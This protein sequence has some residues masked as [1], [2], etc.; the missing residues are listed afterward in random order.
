[1]LE[2]T[3]LII[4]HRGAS[5][6]VPEHTLAA[7]ALA[8]FQGADY[9]EP[10]LVMTRDK[11]LIARHDNRLELST[12]VA[13]LPQFSARRDQRVVDGES[14]SG[15]FSEDFTLAEIRQ[16]RAIE[17]IPALRPANS[18][19]D[20]Q[21]SIPTFNEIIELVQALQQSGGRIIG[22]YPEIKHPAHFQ[23]LDMAAE[24]V[25]IEALQQYGY[26]DRDDPVWL[27]S[28]E[29]QSLRQLRQM[30]A[31]RLVQLL[32][33]KGVSADQ[34]GH[35]AA[36]DYAGMASVRGLHGIREYADAIGVDKRMIVRPDTAGN[37]SVAQA[38]SLVADAHAVG[39][40]V[41][42][43]TFRA[44]N[45]FLPTT[46]QSSSDPAAPGDLAAEL[47]L[48]RQLGVDGFFLDHAD[49]AV[50]LWR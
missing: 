7:Y 22:I 31:L 30:T 26:R 6:Y 41:H 39:L 38:S 12:N 47:T 5:G 50:K 43:W 3:P 23:Q 21:F 45:A 28:F 36:L 37:L 1:M 11:V 20:G 32:A 35:A 42:A 19:F 10:D 2:H 4:A 44:E 9:I 40:A 14:V 49:I 16:L 46:L 17:R 8:I 29:P 24:P 27:Q 34:L 33:A 48:F 15:W 18:R 13:E 25:L